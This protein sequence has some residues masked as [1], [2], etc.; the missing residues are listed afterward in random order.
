MERVRAADVD[1]Q[2]RKKDLYTGNLDSKIRR[3]EHRVQRAAVRKAQI[4]DRQF[5]DLRRVMRQRY[6]VQE[7]R[8]RMREQRNEKERKQEL[9]MMKLTVNTRNAQLIE[10]RK[11]L[12]LDAEDLLRSTQIGKV[13]E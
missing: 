11:R 8:R 4:E 12:K 7:E 5:S 3:A 2:K 13:R 9:K 10:Q 1:E 6:E